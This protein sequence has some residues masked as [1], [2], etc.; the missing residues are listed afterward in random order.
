MVDSGEHN[1]K[2]QLHVT[3]VFRA[4]K[5]CPWVIPGQLGRFL[6]LGEDVL[7]PLH[8]LLSRLGLVGSVFTPVS[9][10]EIRR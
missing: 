5:D 10:P 8:L 2:A 3:D 1:T 9:S 7:N 4:S 6:I